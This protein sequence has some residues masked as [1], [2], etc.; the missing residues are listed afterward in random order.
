MEH[1]IQ[2]IVTDDL[3]RS[4][5]TVFFRLLLV[6]PHWIWLGLWG[7]RGTNALDGSAPAAW[8]TRE[9]DAGVLI[10][11]ERVSTAPFPTPR[12][13]RDLRPFFFDPADGACLSFVQAFSVFPS[14]APAP[15]PPST[16]DFQ[17]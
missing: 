13:G 10:R 6:I 14:V 11:T 17:L 1:P 9:A 12:E 8:L 16:V 2:L 15:K 3:S 4:R 7:P 5:L